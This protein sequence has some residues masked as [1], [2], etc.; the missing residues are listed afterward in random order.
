MLHQMMMKHQTIVHAWISVWIIV[1]MKK[2][3]AFRIFYV[4]MP[5]QQCAIRLVEMLVIKIDCLRIL[6]YINDQS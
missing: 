3:A 2:K 6:N 1:R 4:I 5:V